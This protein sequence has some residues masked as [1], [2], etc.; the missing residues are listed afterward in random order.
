MLDFLHGHRIGILGLNAS[1][2]GGKTTVHIVGTLLEDVTEGVLHS[3]LV[4]PYA[5]SEFIAVKVLK[6]GFEGLVVRIGS[7]FHL[8]EKGKR[9]YVKICVS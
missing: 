7:W 9:W 8:K 1:Q 2:F 6:R 4:H 5:G 3:V